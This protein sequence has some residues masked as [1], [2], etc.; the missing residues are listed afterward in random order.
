MSL[1]IKMNSG[2]AL[3]FSIVLFSIAGF[4]PLVG[5]FTKMNIFLTSIESFM[6]FAAIVAILASVVSTFYYIRVIKILYFEE[7]IVGN[8]YYSLNYIEPFIVT[9]TFFC[10]M[11]FF[12]DPTYLYLISY[13]I[14]LLFYFF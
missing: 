2:L 8:L 9:S 14:G 3:C 5:F 6:Y 12:I 13:K 4:P 10:F 1:L 7:V 11:F